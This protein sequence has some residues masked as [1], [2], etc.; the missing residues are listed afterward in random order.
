MGTSVHRRQETELALGK[1]ETQQQVC[2]GQGGARHT[3]IMVSE[4]TSDT[5]LVSTEIIL[6]NPN[7]RRQLRIYFAEIFLLY[8]YQKKKDMH[9]D[10][11]CSFLAKEA[12]VWLFHIP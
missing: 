3:Y 6:H 8:M 9:P 11:R 1:K 10:L 12:L 7:H 5:H 2:E 4:L